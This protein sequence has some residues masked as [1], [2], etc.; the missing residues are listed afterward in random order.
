MV[1]FTCTVIQSVIVPNLFINRGLLPHSLFNRITPHYIGY[2]NQPTSII[3]AFAP[4]QN[5]AQRYCQ[6]YFDMSTALSTTK[7]GSLTPQWSISWNHLR[8]YK[9]KISKPQRQWTLVVV[10]LNIRCDLH[11]VKSSYCWELTLVSE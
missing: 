2:H 3:V 6:R 8:T 9:M 11:I 7:P 5:L 10:L 1:Y 4:P